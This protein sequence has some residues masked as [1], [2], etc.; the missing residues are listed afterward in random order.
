MLVFP[1]RT[2][3]SALVALLTFLVVVAFPGVASAKVLKKP[4]WLS[5]VAVTD[6][7]GP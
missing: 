7:P 1:T 6:L 2:R 5:K 4:T 3:R